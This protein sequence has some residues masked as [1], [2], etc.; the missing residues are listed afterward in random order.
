MMEVEKPWETGVQ[1]QPEPAMD[2]DEA[3]ADGGLQT[4]EMKKKMAGPGHG[5]DVGDVAV[6][7]LLKAAAAAAAEEEDK[8]VF[9]DPAKGNSN[10]YPLHSLLSSPLLA[11]AVSQSIQAGDLISSIAC[12]LFF[13]FFFNPSLKSNV[14]FFF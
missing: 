5:D 2:D 6:E 9:F 10:A 12:L 13:F 8:S 4:R 7:K 1:H 11:L 14:F 3:A